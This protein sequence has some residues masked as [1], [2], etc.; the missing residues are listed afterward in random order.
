MAE[1]LSLRVSKERV[2]AYAMGIVCVSGF[3]DVSQIRVWRFI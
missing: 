2:D 1:K 3:V